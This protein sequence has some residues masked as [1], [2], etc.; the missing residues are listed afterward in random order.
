MQKNLLRVHLFY[1]GVVFQNEAG[2]TLF[3]VSCVTSE[4]LGGINIRV[5][6]LGCACS[7][8]YFWS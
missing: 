4:V 7:K 1:F 5:Y 2:D 3:A 6:Y 8:I